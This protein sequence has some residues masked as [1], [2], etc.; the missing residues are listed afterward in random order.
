MQLRP[1]LI[2]LA[3]L[4]S[5]HAAIAAPSVPL[6]S[7]ALRAPDAASLQQIGKL[8]EITGRTGADYEVL[9]P[10]NQ[11]ALFALLAPTAA[12][13]DLDTGAT[14]RRQLEAYRHSALT[15][16]GYRSFD[17]VQ[18]WMKNH[19]ERHAA[20][21]SVVDY[22]QSGDK[23][24]LRALRV[25]GANDRAKPALL[26]TAATHGDEL[27]TT[28]VLL[29]LV[30]QM[31][32]GY[33]TD[34]RFTRMVD[35]H[36]IYFVPVVNAD[37]FAETDRYDYGQ[38]PNRSYPYP[39]DPAR[40]PSPSIQAIVDFFHKMNF[41]GS[42]DYHAYGEM[43]M[44]PWAYTYDPI[45]AEAEAKLKGITSRMAETNGYDHGPISKVI[46]VA[47][48]SSCDYY[49]WKKGTMSVAIEIGRSK[50]PNPA[51]IPAYVKSQG[52]SLWRF[53]ESF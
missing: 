28:E 50:I 18:A 37:G 3:T 51:Q 5:S 15:A 46:Y 14:I 23:R 48:G 42:I 9:V 43:V 33:G 41:V 29:N 47:P 1:T 13:T 31:L 53:I 4:L 8:F 32:A 27:I 25:T 34:P 11:A 35:D 10:Q 52:E 39:N 6:S 30:D 2:A 21:A 45:A 38:D 16:R 44:Y 24:P 49:F 20:I 12:L 17:E 36:D 7:Y 19:A 26:I 40:K 22:G